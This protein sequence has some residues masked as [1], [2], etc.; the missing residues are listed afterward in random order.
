MEQGAPSAAA[1]CTGNA[2]VADPL[3]Q[4]LLAQSAQD[5]TAEPDQQTI[6]ALRSRVSEIFAKCLSGSRA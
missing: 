4:P 6:T 5:P 1:Q 2:T 3:F